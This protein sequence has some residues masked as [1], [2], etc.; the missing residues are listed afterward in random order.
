VEQKQYSYRST[1]LV[2]HTTRVETRY[3]VASL[4]KVV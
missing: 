3:Y 4:L 1:V 2:G